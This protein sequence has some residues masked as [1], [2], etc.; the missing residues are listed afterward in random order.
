MELA[1]KVGGESDF[2]EGAET[3]IKLSEEIG[4]VTSATP[5]SIETSMSMTVK[6]SWAVLSFLISNENAKLSS[7]ATTAPEVR[8]TDTAPA[9]VH[10]A[11]GCNLL[12]GDVSVNETLSAVREP[13]KPL[14][15]M[16]KTQISG[17]AGAM[18]TLI[19]EEAQGSE[20]EEVM[21]IAENATAST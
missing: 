10:D 7:F 21:L 20:E 15:V 12:S 17:M 2:Q 18:L 19:V 6:L 5:P 8:H 16:H 11:L 13:V 14:R 4:S 1:E 9:L 3:D